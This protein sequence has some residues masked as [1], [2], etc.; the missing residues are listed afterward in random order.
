MSEVITREYAI[1]RHGVRYIVELSVDVDAIAHDLVNKAA[2]NK[3]GK[4]T[5]VG[6]KIVAK[7]INRTTAAPIHIG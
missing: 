2:R 7:V 3:G 5:E 1:T 4:A 6:S